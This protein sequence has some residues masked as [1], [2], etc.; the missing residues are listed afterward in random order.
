MSKRNVI[1]GR[2]G[3]IALKGLNRSTF[4]AQL[5]KNMKHAISDCGNLRLIGHSPDFLLKVLMKH[6]RLTMLQNVLLRFSVLFQ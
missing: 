4:E 5:A 3:E 6:L 1:I 2:I